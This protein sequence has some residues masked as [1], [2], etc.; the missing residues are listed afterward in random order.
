MAKELWTVR[1]KCYPQ[2]DEDMCWEE[3]VDYFDKRENAVKW[4]S[5]LEAIYKEDC[6]DG[7]PRYNSRFYADTITQE[8]IDEKQR[9]WARQ[10]ANSV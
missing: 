10:M 4:A 3:E 5:Y 1:R 8:E 2:F 9:R 6:W 7:H